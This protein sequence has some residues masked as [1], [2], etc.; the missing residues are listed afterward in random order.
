MLRVALATP[1]QLRLGLDP[2]QLW[3]FYIQLVEIEAA[4]KNL[5]DDLAIVSETLQ[6]DVPAHASSWL[7]SR[8]NEPYR[9]NSGEDPQ[10]LSG[11]DLTAI[12][13]CSDETVRKVALEAGYQAL[14]T[15]DGRHMGID[16][17]A[18]N[19]GCYAIES[20]KPEIFKA[21]I[22]FGLRRDNAAAESIQLAAAP[23]VTQPRNGQHINDSIPTNKA[24]LAT[25]GEVD[26]NSVE[27]RVSRV[28]L[29]PAVYEPKS[30]VVTYAFTEKLLAKTY[31]VVLSARVK[32]RKVEARWSFT[33]DR[34]YETRTKS[35]QR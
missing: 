31:T 14:F 12:D 7:V 6:Y 17:P 35:F 28:G 34:E 19:L 8:A 30:R 26:G 2:A 13:T 5:K 9:R 27:M 3:E 23:M 24:N 21:A 32:G 11:L 33:F 1:W 22:D 16:A 15:L 18:D 4:F 20:N 29:V 10:V 25:M